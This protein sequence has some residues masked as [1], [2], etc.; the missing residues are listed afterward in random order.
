MVTYEQKQHILRV[1]PL[2]VGFETACIQAR[3]PLTDIDSLKE[4][5]DFQRE[6]QYTLAFEE[7]RLAELYKDTVEKA[8]E[9]KLDYKGLRDRLEL[10][11]PER[12]SLKFKGQKDDSNKDDNVQ[13]NINLPDNGRDN[14]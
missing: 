10:L 5:P 8:A 3:I 4:D 9:V 13:L 11:N 6:L 1:L 2:N 12:Y 14:K 7:A